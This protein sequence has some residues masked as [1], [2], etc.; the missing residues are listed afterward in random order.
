VISQMFNVKGNFKK[1]GALFKGQIV[2]H[3]D[4]SSGL[5]RPARRY[6]IQLLATRAGVAQHERGR[7]SAPG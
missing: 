6:G 3:D 4:G 7:R 5:I 1:A 2:I